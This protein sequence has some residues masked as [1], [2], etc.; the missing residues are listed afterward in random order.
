MTDEDFVTRYTVKINE[1][2]V[3]PDGITDTVGEWI[4]LRFDGF[5]EDAT[6][7]LNLKGWVIYD[8]G[9]DEFR[10]EDDVWVE[11]GDVVL[12]GRNG[13]REVNGGITPDYV[14]GSA[15]ALS[16][17]GGDE[18]VIA[19]DG[20]EIDRLEYSSSWP[21]SRAIGIGLDPEADEATT[22]SDWCAQT[23]VYGTHSNTGTPG[24]PNESCTETGDTGGADATSFT[25]VWDEV[26]RG[27]CTGCHGGAGGLSMSDESTAYTNLMDGRVIAG[28][29][30]GSMLYDR[31]TRTGA[32]RM[33]PSGGL[34][35]TQQNLVREWIEEGAIR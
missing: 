15:M 1:F 23:E 16:N 3:N 32:G 4:E 35:V 24:E 19:V 28:D 27:S 10:I 29:P 7:S 8:D 31:I 33:P 21:Y 2:I 14:Y 5:D 17:S 30:A 18:I 13:D 34:S 25:E 11:P 26:I 22:S 12:L 6:A 20:T 9:S